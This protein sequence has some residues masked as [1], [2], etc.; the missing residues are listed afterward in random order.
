MRMIQRA[1]FALV[2]GILLTG[3]SSGASWEDPS[4]ESVFERFLLN[5]YM[6]KD[7]EAYA[8]VSPKDRQALEVTRTSL[9]KYISEDQL[10]EP[11]E[12]LLGTRVAGPYDFKRVRRVNKL[13]EQGPKA[14]EQIE[15]S[16]EYFDGRTA[17]AQMSWDGK[18]WF[19]DMNAATSGQNGEGEP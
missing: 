7:P 3:C 18:R 9:K 12:M 13:G 2:A 15:L 19:V 4:P 6:G 10:P 17:T 14:G 11:H 5:R 8:M 16:L 1:R